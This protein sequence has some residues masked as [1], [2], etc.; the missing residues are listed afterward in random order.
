MAIDNILLKVESL[1]APT[2][3]TLLV[4][5]LEVKTESSVMIEQNSNI[6]YFKPILLEVKSKISNTEKGQNMSTLLKQGDKIS[7]PQTKSF[8]IKSKISPI[9]NSGKKEKNQFIIK[10]K[11][12]AKNQ[13]SIQL[14]MLR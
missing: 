4:S 1:T 14:K 8:M 7:P 10:N 5:Q 12:Q 11:V 6:P 13:M 9:S 2:S 3:S